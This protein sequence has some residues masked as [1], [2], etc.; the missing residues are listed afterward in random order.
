MNWEWVDS[1][2]TQLVEVT[3]PVRQE[4]QS[5]KLLKMNRGIQGRY[6]RNVVN[7]GVRYSLAFEFIDIS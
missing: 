2:Y 7:V 1:S 3:E 5:K 6:P 4:G